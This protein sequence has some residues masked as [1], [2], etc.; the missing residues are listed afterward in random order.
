MKNLVRGRTFSIFKQ[1]KWNL[2]QI[3]HRWSIED[4]GI[5]QLNWTCRSWENLNFVTRKNR[6]F[7]FIKICA[8]PGRLKYYSLRIDLNEPYGITG[9]PFGHWRLV[10]WASVRMR[11]PGR[12]AQVGIPLHQLSLFEKFEQSRIRVS[13]DFVKRNFENWTS[14]LHTILM[15]EFSPYNSENQS[16]LWYITKKWA[17]AKPWRT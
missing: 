6:I 16:F 7:F 12:A 17:N 10:G 2:D 4:W 1:W 3:N 13:I 8:V 9:P 14:V 11:A 5:A 15:H